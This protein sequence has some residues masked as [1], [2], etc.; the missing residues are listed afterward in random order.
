MNIP[1]L[2]WWKPSASS[3]LTVPL[4]NEA[5]DVNTD[6]P[7]DQDW[8][9]MPGIERWWRFGT[10]C[11][12][13]WVF[14]KHSPISCTVSIGCPWLALDNYPQFR[15]ICQSISCRWSEL[16]ISVCEKVCW[17]QECQGL[18]PSG[19][20]LA[21][22]DVSGCLIGCRQGWDGGGRG[23]VKYHWEVE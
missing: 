14:P 1:D 15:N 19:T 2:L 20:F 18:V 11:K 5:I 13:E 7:L 9:S 8:T 21:P 10:R 12:K 23:A 6:P 4:H 16:G 22:F 3:F 17:C